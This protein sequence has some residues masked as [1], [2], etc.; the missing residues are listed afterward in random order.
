MLPFC[1]GV[2]VVVGGGVGCGMAFVWALFIV[3]VF[4]EPESELGLSRLGLVLLLPVLVMAIRA[5]LLVVFRVLACVLSP[6]SLP[7]WAPPCLIPQE[8]EAQLLHCIMQLGQ[9]SL[10]CH[11]RET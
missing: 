7:P 10:D 8:T 5:F 1:V 9:R 4:R 6:P 11:I 3:L 2:I